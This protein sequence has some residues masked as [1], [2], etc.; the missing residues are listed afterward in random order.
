M[1]IALST[2]I[3]SQGSADEVAP[4]VANQSAPFGR[5]TLEG[6]GAWTASFTG[7]MPASASITTDDATNANHW[8]I[9]DGWK[10]APSATG[11]GSLAA[12][13]S[14]GI[15]YTNGA[16]S[17]SEATIT[18]NT[19]ADAYDVI[20][21]AELLAALADAETA[22][23]ST[24]WTVY[25]R[26]GVV[27]SEEDDRVQIR[28]IEFNGALSD[29][30]EG[31]DYGSINYSA[32]PTLSGGSAHITART[33]FSPII[34]GSL[35]ITG[36]GPIKVSGMTFANIPDSESYNRDDGGADTNTLAGATTKQLIVSTSGSF[37][38]KSDVWITGN[39]F[40][41]RAFNSDNG[42]WGTCIDISQADKAV[43]ED[44]DF[45][46]FYI[47]TIF[48]SCEYAACRRN[49][50][51]NFLV[52]AIRC[53][54]N[55]TADMSGSVV[56]FKCTGNYI[57]D[58]VADLDWTGAHG[59]GV[60]VGTSSDEVDHDITISRNYIYL[61][62]EALEDPTSGEQR[63]SQ[64]IYTDD[65]T[66]GITI[67]GTIAE[68]FVC[69]TASAGIALWTGTVTCANNT[70][71]K[72]TINAEPDGNSGG[73]DIRVRDGT[74]HLV[75]GNIVTAI[76]DEGGTHTATNNH[77]IDH[78]TNSGTASSYFDTFDGP[79]TDDATLGP[80]WTVRTD[81][82][83]NLKA[84]IDSVFNDKSGGSGEGLG[85]TNVYAP[86]PNITRWNETTKNTYLELDQGSDQDSAG[87]TIVFKAKL[88]EID[89]TGLLMSL[90]SSYIR[91]Q[92]TGRM[93]FL[94]QDTGDVNFVNH[95]TASSELSVDDEVCVFVAID[96]TG[97]NNTKIRRALNSASPTN[98]VN[99][100]TDQS[101]ETFDYDEGATGIAMGASSSGTS[102]ADFEL[103]GFVWMAD[104]Y[105]D[106]EGFQSG[107]SG[108]TWWDYFFDSNND[109]IDI[110]NGDG[111]SP[112]SI[113]PLFFQDG[114]AS[115]WLAGTN[116]GDGGT[117]TVT[118]SNISDV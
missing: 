65:V 44:N 94:L 88:K 1:K 6:D 31:V 118:G 35:E 73:A 8:Q 95:T 58:Y 17:S 105:L 9:V 91:Y 100:S 48:S 83:V 86:W 93:R 110:A 30:N 81:T 108:P 55:R 27:L 92:A 56:E 28:G 18:I 36:S 3:T 49:D 96:T 107:G 99:T 16:G 111:I 64:G 98:L 62:V 59:D 78:D 51:H 87:F 12:S 75:T 67:D 34:T 70:V 102:H 53:M 29:A 74:N 79:M 103:H 14:L 15:T 61:P 66:G 41:S 21:S 23:A 19:T 10:L 68:N 89:A 104:E 46:G 24:D 26:D 117:F 20:S 63:V 60:Q 13:Y 5:D 80:Q 11:A 45:D 106:P 37:P 71:V 69:C 112:N 72:D 22:G 97:T 114:E 2:S 33:A 90:G 4:V 40:G 115:D 77:L 76:N 43:V 57:W 32:T 101:G 7:G 52:D 84:D 25:V 39:R 85:H 116:E 82:S 50:Y 42:Y 109:P 38:N 47:G 113:T 54:N